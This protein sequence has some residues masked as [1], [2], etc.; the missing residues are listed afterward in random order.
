MSHIVDALLYL[1]L[2]EPRALA[3]LNRSMERHDE[4]RQQHFHK[5]EMDPPGSKVFCGEVWA[6]AFNHWLSSDI[7]RLVAGAPWKVPER[8]ILI[9]DPYDSDEDPRASTAHEL[10]VGAMNK[11]RR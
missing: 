4:E 3:V 6:G 2:E 7:E 8:V 11:A 10:Q 5:V 1:T 9:V